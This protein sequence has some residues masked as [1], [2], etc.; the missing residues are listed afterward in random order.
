[1]RGGVEG[2]VGRFGK[3]KVEDVRRGEEVGV[4]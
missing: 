2:R 1:M 4:E 3:M